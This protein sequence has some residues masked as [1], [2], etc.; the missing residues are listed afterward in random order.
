[1]FFVCLCNIIKEA[2]NDTILFIFI[3]Y[4]Y[5]G[6]K[7]FF[8]VLK[9]LLIWMNGLK[10]AAKYCNWKDPKVSADKNL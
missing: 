6:I 1:M 3:F 9:M 10:L 8:D 4:T 2:A 5:K 7:M